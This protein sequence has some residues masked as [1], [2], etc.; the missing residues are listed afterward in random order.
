MRL[1]FGCL[2]VILGTVSVLL[3]GRYGYKGAVAGELDAWISAVVFG[4][5]ALC[6]L[7]LDAA[8]V[9]LWFRDYRRGATV[10]GVIGAAGLIV[11]FS[12]SMAALSERADTL[13]ATRQRTKAEVSADRAEFKRLHEERAKLAANLTGA[14]DEDAVTTAR[15][16]VT[17]AEGMRRRECGDGD[18]RQRGPNCRLRETE[19]IAARSALTAMLA[20]KGLTERI[21]RLDA[22]AA[23]VRRRLEG[24][25]PVEQ[26]NPLAAALEGMLGAGAAALVSWQQ[27]LIAATFELFLVGLMVGFELLGVEQPRSAGGEDEA[28]SSQ[29]GTASTLGSRPRSRGAKGARAAPTGSVK[30]FL[31]GQVAS[32]RGERT[33]VKVLLHAYRDWC[34]EAGKRAVELTDFVRALQSDFALEPGK[35]GRAYALDVVVKHT[36]MA[37]ACAE[38]A[39]IN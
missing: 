12:N 22:E 7:V 26:A 39:A 10:L 28:R 24:A 6:P 37:A 25:P 3:A 2:A 33:D 11:T 19:E 27:A 13:Q 36:V 5:I 35:D 31:A 23:T 18:P 21:A 1:G 8:A 9:R 17:S 20:N 16:N 29:R 4:S 34:L 30:A 38:R 32:A 15:N 14:A